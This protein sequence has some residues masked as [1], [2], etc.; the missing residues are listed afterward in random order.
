[1]TRVRETELIDILVNLPDVVPLNTGK[2]LSG[3]EYNIYFCALGFEDRCITI[4]EQLANVEDFKCELALFFQFSTNIDDNDTN[5]SRL[6]SAF[7]KF[8]DSFNCLECDEDD[9]TKN[10][11]E[12][13]SNA[14]KHYNKP[15]I[16]F[17]ISVCSAKLILSAM[18]VLLQFDIY[19]KVVYSEATTYHPTLEEFKEDSKKWTTEEG[20]GIARGVGK[21]I[22]SLN[23]PGARKENPD[24]V[25][26]FPTYKPERTKAII[27]YID[28]SLSLRPEKRIIW[29]IGDPNMDPKNKKERKDIIRKINDI[30]EDVQSYEIC[31]LDYKKTLG[32]LEQI[33]INNN[34]DSH[35]NISALGSKMQ[36]LGI[37]IFCYIRC[38]VSVYFA[39]PKEYNSKQYSEGYKNTWQIEFGDISEIRKIL[40]QVGTLEIIETK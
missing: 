18:N 35:L 40:N 31:T 10:L 5:R 38:E 37:S 36:S 20:F 1:M 30:P 16:I 23:Y 32:V 9:F 8:A 6:T 7:E 15:K 34:L 12:V 26:A 11:R 13:L 27:T 3:S 14:V 24:L 29:I 33:Y 19:L 25:I 21:V 39:I 17:D 22:S 28:E 2:E 4:A